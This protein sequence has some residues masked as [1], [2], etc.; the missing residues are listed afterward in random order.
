MFEMFLVLFHDDFY[1]GF[2]HFLNPIIII[3]EEYFML[4]LSR[5]I[6]FSILVYFVIIRYF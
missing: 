2:I 4:N 3:L 1:Q 5:E 6:H